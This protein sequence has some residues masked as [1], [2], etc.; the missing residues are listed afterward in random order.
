MQKN[1]DNS[2]VQNNSR[3]KSNFFLLFFLKDD[4]PQVYTQLMPLWNE[5]LLYISPTEWKNKNKKKQKQMKENGVCLLYNSSSASCLYR[6]IFRNNTLH[7]FFCLF[8]VFFG[9]IPFQNRSFHYK[10]LL[11]YNVHISACSTFLSV[12][13]FLLCCTVVEL[14]RDFLKTDA[15]FVNVF[16]ALSTKHPVKTLRLRNVSYC[17]NMENGDV[18][19]WNWRDFIQL[20]R[21]ENSYQPTEECAEVMY[22]NWS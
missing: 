19:L 1:Y 18:Q 10:I 6:F 14:Q 13:T 11:V 21:S 22:S 9:P 15:F 17:R 16:F 5:H 4:R 8:F 20:Q 3:L 2:S 7:L 12:W